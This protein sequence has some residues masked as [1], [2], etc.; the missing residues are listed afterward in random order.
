MK[1]EIV[2]VTRNSG[3]AKEFTEIFG[4]SVKFLTLNDIGFTDE[5]VEDGLSFFENSFKKCLAVYNFSKRAVMADDSGLC[6]EALGNE[7]GIHSAR[8]GGKGLTDKER[9]LLLLNNL[10]GKDNLN[11]CFV[12]SLVL[13]INPIRFFTVQEEIQGVITFSP[14]GENGFGYDPIFYLPE[15][16]K[17]MAELSSNEK[18]RIS[19]RAKASLIMKKII[20]EISF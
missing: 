17:T 15:Y 10:R 3:K 11:A 16:G 8:Y 6:V 9:Y 5:I 2:L 13:M 7:P 14:K 20:S 19:H 18:N 1:K 4:N 12:C